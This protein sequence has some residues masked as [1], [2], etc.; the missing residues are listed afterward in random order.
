M[1]TQDAPATYIA[2]N[3]GSLVIALLAA[4]WLPVRTGERHALGL[5]IALLG[6]LGLTLF[7]GHDLE[8]VRRWLALGPLNLHIGYLVL[9]AL[10]VIMARLRP[11]FAAG[12]LVAAMAICT[13]QP[14]RAAVLA[15]AAAAASRLVQQRDRF[16]LAAQIA[17]VA[18]VLIVWS[19]P[20]PLAPVPFVE[21]VLQDAWAA[22]TV[23]GAIL[24]LASLAPLVLI[25][26]TGR[27]A[28]PLVAFVL[29]AGCAALLGNYPSILIGYGAAPILGLGLALAA[30]RRQ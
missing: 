3:L 26:T 16:A 12:M 11:S 21:G 14:D 18:A 13:L 2:V 10:A 24:L 22:S 20:D 9:P 28:L 15:L 4:R 27:A 30:L 25:K 29:A 7:V 6:L 23:A 1:A 19:I 17:G 5:G 8:G